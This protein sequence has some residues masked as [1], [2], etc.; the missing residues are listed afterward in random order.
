VRELRA[1]YPSSGRSQQELGLRYGV[2]QSC[3][4]A[5]VSRK[6]KRKTWTHI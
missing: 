3:V 4:S 1:A 2:S 6:R 5:V